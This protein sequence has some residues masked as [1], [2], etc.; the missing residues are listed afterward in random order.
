MC[1]CCFY[2]YT[3]SSLL[4]KAILYM[5][6][7]YIIYFVDCFIHNINCCMEAYAIVQ[8]VIT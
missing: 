4:L 3:K 8:L 5:Y 7:F 1:P 6:I 2:L